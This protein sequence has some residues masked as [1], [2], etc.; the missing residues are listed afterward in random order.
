MLPLTSPIS[1]RILT[2]NRYLH[3]LNIG[4]DANFRLKRK[5]VSSEAANPGLS[6]GWGYFVEDK[7]YKK[8]LKDHENDVEPK[9]DC[10]RHNAVNLADTRPGQ[11][12]AAT[13]VGTVECTRHNMKR[14][15]AVGDLQKGER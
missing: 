7:E 10:S 8:H 12:Y 9:S 2:F 3:A 1:S 4:L 15:S 11:G 14:P 5:D 13:G 6:H